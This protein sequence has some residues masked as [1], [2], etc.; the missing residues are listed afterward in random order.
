MSTGTDVT[1]T[2]VN[3]VILPPC[4]RKVIVAA[5]TVLYPFP[6]KS[7]AKFT[8]QL[9]KA[10]KQMKVYKK[11]L[12]TK[13]VTFESVVLNIFTSALIPWQSP[14]YKICDS[15]IWNNE[16]ES[17]NKQTYTQPPHTSNSFCPVWGNGI[18]YILFI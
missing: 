10:S 18:Q 1:G 14:K 7:I 6:L 5:H 17:Q 4:Y 2:D 15:N 16:D 8:K 12:W 11:S 9:L 3:T 13:W